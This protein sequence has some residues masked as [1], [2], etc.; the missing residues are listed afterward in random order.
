MILG[1]YGQTIELLG[2]TE[3]SL[4]L[5]VDDEGLQESLSVELDA[6]EVAQLRDALAAWLEKRQPPWRH[7][8]S[9]DSKGIN[10]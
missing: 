3:H 10:A 7:D 5:S 1:K 4:M 6:Y 9:C 2:H 8:N